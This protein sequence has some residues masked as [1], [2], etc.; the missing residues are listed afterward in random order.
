MLCADYPGL[1]R[2]SLNPVAREV[3]YAFGVDSVD[4][5]GAASLIRGTDGYFYGTTLGSSD[6]GDYP[7]GRGTIFR[8][9]PDG[10]AMTR[11][12][13]CQWVSGTRPHGALVEAPDGNFY[14]VMR[15]GANWGAGCV[16]RITPSG[17]YTVLHHFGQNN[18]LKE[19]YGDLML[20]TDGQ[21]YGT[22]SDLGP[23]G[24][25]GVFRIKTNGT[26]YKVLHSFN[27]ANGAAPHGGLVQAAD[28]HLYG[29]TTEGGEGANGTVFRIK[30]N[31]PS[32]PENRRPVAVN[33]LGI[34]I[35][36]MEVDIDVR[37]NDYD[38]DGDALMVAIKNGPTSGTAVVRLGGTIRY[39]PNGSSVVSDEFTYTVTDGRGGE[40]SATVRITSTA[41]VPLLT[42]GVYQGLLTLDP[43]LSGE[44]DVPRGL[45]IV[46]LGVGGRFTGVLS[47]Q[48]KRLTLRG[49]FSQA[50]KA[51]VHLK[52]PNRKL[53]TLFLSL[54]AGT[55]NMM[56]GVLFG[57]ELW[58]GG[59]L[60]SQ[61]SDSLVKETF[62]AVLMPTASGL[63]DG[64]GFAVMKLSPNGAVSM[65]GKLG[66]GSKLSW[67]SALVSGPESS[68]M[69]PVFSEPFAGGF[70]GGNGISALSAAISA[71]S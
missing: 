71:L 27:G 63:P 23:Q 41:P 54:E 65:V 53:A 46:K 30:L 68:T 24:Y 69:L 43:E 11:L 2:V 25:G 49:T 64:H 18:D 35:A 20:G 42:P 22:A 15:V 38:P 37:A 7:N 60:P 56:R 9:A 40:A 44:G 14:G 12:H 57:P 58:S 29:T 45:F 17:V 5:H 3:V 55:P 50:G 59:A 1:W 28:G 48:R 62:T 51:V 31:L 16:Y 32:M 8:I 61:A 36:G 6:A 4:G 19:P 67:S 26:G 70:C 21:L 13:E 33:D 52:L 47:T 39:T 34:S 10:T 66:D